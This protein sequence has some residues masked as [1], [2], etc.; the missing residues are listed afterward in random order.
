MI[1]LSPANQWDDSNSNPFDDMKRALMLGS[2]G[3][4]ERESEIMI[5]A[6]GKREYDIDL[7]FDLLNGKLR[8][9]LEK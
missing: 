4:S 5:E 7:H 8:R 6:I 9:S 1:K 2:N 3:M